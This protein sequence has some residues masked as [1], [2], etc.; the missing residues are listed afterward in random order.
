MNRVFLVGNIT[1]DIY[2]DRLLIKGVTRPF[3]RVILMSCRPRNVS[4]LRIT[5][6]DEKAEL[7]YP[8]LQKGSQIAVIGM[9]QSRVYRE[10][11]VHEVEAVNLAL[12][13]NIDWQ[14][15]E[16][17]RQKRGLE[18]ANATTSEIFV[19]GSVAEKNFSWRQRNDRQDLAVLRLSMA[20]EQCAGLRVMVYGALA[21]LVHPYLVNDSKVAVDGHFQSKNGHGPEVVAEHIAFLENINWEAGIAAQEALTG[22]MLDEE[23]Q[24]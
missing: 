2:Y 4:G 15:G 11:L 10:K 16:S 24:P 8:Y 23:Q 5:L 18:K 22:T 7:F 13:K 1:G 9:F 19:V 20:S 6:W 3:L 14:R 12:L 21:E 17:E